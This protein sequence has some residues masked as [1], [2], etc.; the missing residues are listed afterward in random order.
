MNTEIF[1]QLEALRL[2]NEELER[3]AAS[4]ERLA[5][6]ARVIARQEETIFQAWKETDKWEQRHNFIQDAF[7]KSDDELRRLRAPM[8]ESVRRAWVEYAGL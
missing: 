7:Y 5:L 4:N 3:E 8:D 6:L 2:R 1:K